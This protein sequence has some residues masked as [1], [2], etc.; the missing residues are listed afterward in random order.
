MV[1]H[2]SS[3]DLRLN[4]HYHL[5][6][7]RRGLRRARRLPPGACAD[8]R[9]GRGDPAPHHR[10]H[11]APPRRSRARPR[12]GRAEHRPLTLRVDAQRAAYAGRRPARPRP[13]PAH[14]PQGTPRRVGPRRG[15]VRARARA[16]PARATLPLPA[17][18]TGRAGST[19]HARRRPHLHRTEAAVGRPHHA[20]HDDAGCVHRAPGRAGPEAAQE[21]PRELR[22]AL[23]QHKHRDDIVPHTEPDHP[24]FVERSPRNH[25]FLRRT[26]QKHSSAS[27]DRPERVLD[28]TP[29]RRGRTAHRASWPTHARGAGRASTDH[30]PRVANLS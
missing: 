5:A 14:A 30:F 13:P 27:A 25:L 20:R 24:G 21:H 23:G 6:H 11:R 26:K 7:A 19:S 28:R 10:A 16:R 15:S 2:R 1:V 12:R 8:A 18:P 9:G 17:P 4:V 3:S 22:R 29:S